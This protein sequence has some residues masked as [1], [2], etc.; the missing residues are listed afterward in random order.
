MLSISNSISI[1]SVE[2][3][4]NAPDTDGQAFIDRVVAAGG[5]LTALEQNAVKQLVLDLKS[6]GIWTSI[7]AA[8]PNIGSSALACKQNLVSTS[9]VGTFSGTSTFT[10]AGVTGNGTT[11]YMDTGYNPA[12]SG[13]LNSSHL[14]VYSRTIGSQNDS[15]EIGSGTT[16][17]QQITIRDT[18]DDATV[19]LNANVNY[20]ANM[21]S[22]GFYIASRVNSSQVKLYKN[23]SLLGTVSRISS[24]LPNRNIFVG[25]VNKSAGIEYSN[26]Q[27]AFSSI[28][29]GLTDTQA[30]NYYIAVQDFQLALGR[31][32]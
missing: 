26:K 29:A 30:A 6:Y 19:A 3:V 8:Y 31:P 9:F 15:G 27:I 24:S 25:G 22:H 10:S 18:G 1:G 23:N 5:S 14:S 7:Q 4:L 21:D 16:I 32:V 12:T 13:A 28:G 11:G 20:V 2:F 17:Y